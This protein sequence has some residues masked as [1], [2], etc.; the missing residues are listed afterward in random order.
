MKKVFIIMSLMLLA[1]LLKG[2]LIVSLGGGYTGAIGLDDYNIPLTSTHFNNNLTIVKTNVGTFVSSGGFS[3]NASIA[4]SLSYN[5]AIGISGGYYKSNVDV[6]NSFNTRMTWWDNTLANG[7]KEW[8]N[9]GTISIIPIS[10]NFIYRLSVGENI[11]I[12][13]SAGPTLYLTSV[14]LS[15]NIGDTGT[16]ATSNY[17]YSDWYDLDTLNSFSKTSFGG[18]VSVDL[19][20]SISESMAIYAGGTYYIAGAITSNWEIVES[21]YTGEWGNL[22]RTINEDNKQLNI[23]SDINISTFSIE[24]G[25]KVYL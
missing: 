15:G 18:K 21:K 19:E 11:K 10:F 17:W 20:Y 5:V 9:S 22:V 8:T 7:S 3:V 23:T 16:L 13:F 4:A 1:F 6:T 14:D 12:N 24:G 2:E 25:I